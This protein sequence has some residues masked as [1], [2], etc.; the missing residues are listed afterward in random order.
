MALKYKRSSIQLIMT[1]LRV[2]LP[3]P[4]RPRVDSSSQLTS[5]FSS[6][7]QSLSIPPSS[8]DPTY[9]PDGFSRLPIHH[10]ALP[11]LPP[12]C[13]A[14]L[15]LSRRHIYI[16]NARTQLSTPH[17]YLV[18]PS[19]YCTIILACIAAIYDPTMS[20]VSHCSI[21]PPL[22]YH[23]QHSPLTSN[24]MSLDSCIEKMAEAR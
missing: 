22:Y 23:L 2:V 18:T 5:P 6:S 8:S 12:C 7:C 1:A 11:L 4:A 19:R 9:N 14:S 3:L 21:S 13:P 20:H 24:V 15:F 16:P 17:M 10:T